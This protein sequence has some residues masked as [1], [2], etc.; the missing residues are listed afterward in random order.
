MLL[1][2][3]AVVNLNM[4][5]PAVADDATPITKVLS[6]FVVS[7]WRY[8]GLAKSVT[9]LWNLI[10]HYISKVSKTNL[11]CW[12]LPRFHTEQ[13]LQSV[14]KDICQTGRGNISKGR[15][16]HTSH[17]LIL[18]R[19]VQG[20]QPKD[21]AWFH[22]WPCKDSWAEHLQGKQFNLKNIKIITL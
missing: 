19:V 12:L 3:P 5:I 16:T 14:R 6:H 8:R 11:L 22:S 4:Q 20:N 7:V 13:L 15:W 10:A 18:T 2:T 21:S 9:E 17:L 1:F